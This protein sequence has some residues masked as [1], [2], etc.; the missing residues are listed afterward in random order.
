MQ[1]THAGIIRIMPVQRPSCRVD[2]FESA[3]RMTIKVRDSLD[4]DL[5][6]ITAIYAHAVLHG[7][8][9]LELQ[10]PDRAEMARRRAAIL[11]GHFPYLVAE[12]DGA[13]VGFTYAG[14]YRTRPAYRFAVENSVYVAPD[15]QRGG[16]GRALLTTLID[17]CTVLGFRMMVAVIGDSANLASIQMHAIAG[18]THAGILPGIG[19]K[20][21]QWVDSV[22]L[23][24]P[25][26]QG[27]TTAP[28]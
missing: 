9:S 22:L 5:D 26:G 7:L 21:G 3:C 27:T 12:R 4:D 2:P 10:S 13:I 28:D 24:R 14:P 19:W 1:Q 15:Q 11:A 8:A 6:A 23:T 18:F 16:V 20:H 25:L 17:R